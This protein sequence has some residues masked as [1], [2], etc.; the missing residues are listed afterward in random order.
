MTLEKTPQ[1]L[2]IEGDPHSRE[3]MN[4]LFSEL[5]W[6]CDSA[7]DVKS[8]STPSEYDM[9]VADAAMPG[10][11]GLLLL[12]E[13]VKAYPHLPIVAVSALRSF[14]QSRECLK[15]GISDLL[16][17]KAD[18]SGV[19]KVLKNILQEHKKNDFNQKIY[20]H[21]V[22]ESTSF[23]F[24][25]LELSRLTSWVPPI[26]SRLHAAAIFDDASTL[27][28][29]LALQEV[30]TN[31]LEHGNLELRSEWKEE[32]T[33][34]G[35]DRFSLIREERLAD[36]KWSDKKVKV[37][38]TYYNGQLTVVIKD[39]GKGFLNN[40]RTHVAIAS[41]ENPPVWGRGL[42]LISSAVDELRFGDN[43]SEVTLLKSTNPRTE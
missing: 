17:T 42:Q 36:R 37:D 10:T 41:P 13:L 6:S 43:G 33:A 11:E 14:E 23:E 8:V 18:V 9:I 3:F 16:Q 35:A 4:E 38:S 24:S 2:L 5:G 34:N 20:T 12:S 1:V 19:E 29:K 40:L 39:E 25:S 21:V 22:R 32:F 15:A 7:R 30:V 31:A 26:L 28:L 27:R